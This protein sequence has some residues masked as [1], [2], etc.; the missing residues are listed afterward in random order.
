MVKFWLWGLIEELKLSKTCERFVTNATCVARR[1]SRWLFW[2]ISWLNEVWLK[3]WLSLCCL[4]DFWSMV[5]VRRCLC[6]ALPPFAKN[7]IHL[8]VNRLWLM[9][10]SIEVWAAFWISK[11][12]AKMA[13]YCEMLNLFAK[14]TA[15]SR[16]LRLNASVDMFAPKMFVWLIFEW[17]L[18]WFE[19]L[20]FVI[21][22]ERTYEKHVRFFILISLMFTYFFKRGHQ[23]WEH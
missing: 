16:K 14:T 23:L 9:M 22:L 4:L 1:R 10:A 11:N 17:F 6:D 3:F 13:Q 2:I 12:C 18:S 21:S 20:W 15:F 19:A 7:E 8:D 5:D